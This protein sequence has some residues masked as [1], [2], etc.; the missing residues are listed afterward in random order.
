M[1]GPADVGRVRA[2]LDGDARHAEGV[3]LIGVDTKRA[4]ELAGRLEEPGDVLARPRR[5]VLQPPRL[6]GGRAARRGRAARARMPRVRA[7]VRLLHLGRRRA[8]ER[9]ALGE[10]DEQVA[11]LEARDAACVPRGA[12]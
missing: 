7:R 1:D 3:E 6:R 4:A 5:Q 8:P 11:A 12:K 9:V 10:V 2:H